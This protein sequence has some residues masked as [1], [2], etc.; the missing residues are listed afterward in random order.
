MTIQAILNEA[1]YRIGNTEI[2]QHISVK[3]KKGDRIGLIGRNGS[4]K[5]TLLQVI[6]G[7]LELTSGSFDWGE[8]D[9]TIKYVR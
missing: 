4:G 7:E 2:F 8:S 9:L 6:A 3:M 1:A 5:S